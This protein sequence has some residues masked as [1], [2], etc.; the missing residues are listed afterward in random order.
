MRM[1]SALLVIP[2][3]LSIAFFGGA[4]NIEASDFDMST[5][6]T[7]P[8]GAGPEGVAPVE[9]GYHNAGPDSA[10][11]WIWASIPSGVPAPLA[12]MTPAQWDALQASV[13]PDGL[14]NTA[15]LYVNYLN[16]DQLVFEFESLLGGGGQPMIGL[17]PGIGDSMSYA[18][19]MPMDAPG[20]AGLIIEEP[21]DLAAEY[22]PESG[23]AMWLTASDWGRFS[24][25]RCD[26]APSDCSDLSTCFG[27]R[28]SMTD[29]IAG[30]FELVDDGSADPT[31]GC[32]PLI[33]YTSGNIAVIERGGCEFGTKAKNAQDAGATAVIFVNNGLC[34]DPNPP[35]PKCAIWMGGGVDGDLVTI[36]VLMLSVNDGAP[37][38]AALVADTPVSGRLGAVSGSFALDSEVVIVAG[39]TD[40][41]MTDNIS[42]T[43]VVFGGIFAD[44]F[45]SGDTSEWT[46]VQP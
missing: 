12:S 25:G 36:P 17:D 35:S 33:G 46:L 23:N 20:I 15:V 3:C 45:E 39:N 8:H 9:V 24:T 13:V 42:S 18:L 22:K 28:L 21:T 4:P 7:A 10:S 27:P 16:C 40:P 32:L 1:K 5:T 19:E 43:E 38:V 30:D 29:P 34:V 37:I 6:V 44:G 41:D 26:A 11:I 31:F 2:V 14:G